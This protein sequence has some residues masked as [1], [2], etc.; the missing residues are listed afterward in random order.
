VL[1]WL[2][3]R[4]MLKALADGETDAAA[5][6]ALADYRLR[7]TPDQLRDAL[8]T[9]QGLDPAYGFVRRGSKPRPF[10][11]PNGK[12]ECVQNMRV[13]QGKSQGPEAVCWQVFR[14][15]RRRRATA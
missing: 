15:P 5:L 13:D 11:L 2:G 7:A 9:C 8:G 3:A 14:R 4:R 12:L 10:R 6:A 1:I